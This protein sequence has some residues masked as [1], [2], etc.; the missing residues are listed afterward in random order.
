VGVAVGEEEEARC[1]EVVVGVCIALLG[2]QRYSRVQNH[3][4]VRYPILCLKFRIGGVL[5]T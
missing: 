1:W 5:I 4:F 3:R 2:P